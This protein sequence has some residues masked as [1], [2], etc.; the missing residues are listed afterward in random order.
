MKRTA[1]QWLAAGSFLLTVMSLAE[2]RPQYG[3]ILHVATRIA[4]ASLDPADSTEGDSLVRRNLV[5]LVFDPLVSMDA[6]GKP[7]PVLAL[8]WRA[9]SAN[10]RWQFWLR[11][12]VKFHDGSPLTPE[13][14]AASLRTGNPGWTILAATDS[15]IIQTNADDPDLPIE[16]AMPRNS[17]AKKISG[18]GWVGTGPFRITN[19]QQQKSATLAADENY[20]NGRAFVDAIEVEFGKSPHDQLI[21]FDLGKVQLAEVTTDQIHRLTGEGRRIVCS[22]PIELLA[23]IFSREPQ[24]S[25]DAKLREVI[26]RSIDRASIRSGV[27]Q[28]SGE[29]SAAILPNWVSGYA[30]VFSAN[31]ELT[32][33][34]EERGEIQRA[35]TLTLGYDPDDALG[36]L[37]AERIALNAR[38]AGIS[39]QTVPGGKADIRVT[40]VTI[41]TANPRIALRAAARTLGLPAPKVVGTSPEDVY[42]AES[43]LL[44]SKRIIPLFQ[45]PLCYAASSSL[46]NWRMGRD[47]SWDLADVSIGGTQ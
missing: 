29:P 26:A 31:R 33:A 30:F 13:A 35:P 9:E 43:E 5:R 36:R 32:T 14:V 1:W 17:I 38:D 23:L 25:D 22:G 24:S 34:Q 45:I 47:G 46:Q 41:S 4:P 44:R 19:W 3:G 10:Q 15:V 6:Q 21:D 37:L 18:G 40:R 12:N 2:T 39:L 20:W 8:S 11:K 28:D 7:Q 27:F 16:L 42:K